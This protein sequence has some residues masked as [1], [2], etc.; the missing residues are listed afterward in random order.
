[1]G[2]EVSSGLLRFS[3]PGDSSLK[4]FFFECPSLAPKRTDVGIR[5]LFKAVD[6]GEGVP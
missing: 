6:K 2:G 5:E 1:M 3:G 4:C